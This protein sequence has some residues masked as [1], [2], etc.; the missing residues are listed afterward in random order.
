MNENK[1][2]IIL[3]VCLMWGKTGAWTQAFELSRTCCLLAATR[4]GLLQIVTVTH[5]NQSGTYL[6][7]HEM[8]ALNRRWSRPCS[9]SLRLLARRLRAWKKGVLKVQLILRRCRRL[10]FGEG[11]LTVFN[12]LPSCHKFWYVFQGD[13]SMILLGMDLRLI[14]HQFSESI[15]AF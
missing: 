12:H 11:I 7:R 9:S 10:A 15:L 3:C 13:C 6:S 14:S 2:Q 1:R 4:K 5:L 8:E